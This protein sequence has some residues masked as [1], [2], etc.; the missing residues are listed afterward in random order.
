MTSSDIEHFVH[1]IKTLLEDDT[2]LNILE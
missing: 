2:H 1:E